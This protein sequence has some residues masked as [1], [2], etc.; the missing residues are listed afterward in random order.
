[1]RVVWPWRAARDVALYSSDLAGIVAM[2]MVRLACGNV[3]S[4]ILGARRYPG[5]ARIRALLERSVGVSESVIESWGRVLLEDS[6]ITCEIKCQ[7]RIRCS[8]GALY[9]VDM[10]IDGWLILEF[11]GMLKYSTQDDPKREARRQHSLTNTGY[12]ILRIEYRHL[13]EGIFVDMVRQALSRGPGFRPG[14]WSIR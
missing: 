12:G 10:L 1:M 11:D 4:R 6:D 5:K 2:D 14:S 7:V 8:D 9:R 13:R 3:S